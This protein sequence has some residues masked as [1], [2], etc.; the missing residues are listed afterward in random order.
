MNFGGINNNDYDRKS[1]IKMKN[2]ISGSVDWVS[3][4]KWDNC[5]LCVDGN[6]DDVVLFVI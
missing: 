3:R 6:D 4:T 1:E 5:D 2:N